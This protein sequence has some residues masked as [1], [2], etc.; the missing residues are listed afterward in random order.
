MSDF[1]EIFV[2]LVV[3]VVKNKRWAYEQRNRPHTAFFGIRLNFHAT[4]GVSGFSSYS[5]SF[6][7]L[8]Y[9]HLTC[10]RLLLGRHRGDHY[11]TVVPVGL[12]VAGTEDAWK[13]THRNEI[14]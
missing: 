8:F 11:L 14:K 4:S 12:C 1:S 9:P 5:I 10:W 13:G 2:F 6:N 7:C 3:K